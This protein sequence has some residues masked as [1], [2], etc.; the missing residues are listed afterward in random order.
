MGCSVELTFVEVEAAGESDDF[1]SVG[2]KGDDGSLRKA[3]GGSVAF[4]AGPKRAFSFGLD[5]WVETGLDDEVAFA[6]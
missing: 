3:V 2:V 1:A 6:S 5:L 4:D